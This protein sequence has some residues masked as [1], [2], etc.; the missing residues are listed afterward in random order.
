VANAERLQHLAAWPITI[1][2]FD[3]KLDRQDATPAYEMRA[4]FFENGVNGVLA[5]DYGSFAIEGELKEID[6]LEPGKCK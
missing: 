4:V 3:P 5:I 2:Y 6:F 1:A